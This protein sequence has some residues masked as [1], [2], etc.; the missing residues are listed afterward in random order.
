LGRF[1]PKFNEAH[2]ASKTICKVR[3]LKSRIKTRS[4]LEEIITSSEEVF[5]DF[6]SDMAVGIRNLG[7][8]T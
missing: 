5:I 4:F 2:E 6:E 3:S 8:A 1:E 7:D